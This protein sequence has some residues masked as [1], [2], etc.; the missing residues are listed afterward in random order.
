MFHFRRPDGTPCEPE[1]WTALLLELPGPIDA[2]TDW[3]ITVNGERR[4]ATLQRVG[5]HV[6]CVCP[7]PECGAGRYRIVADH[8]EIGRC[9]HEVVVPA[10]KL[11]DGALPRILDDLNRR[12]PHALATALQRGGALAGLNFSAPEDVTPEAEFL[13]LRDV[14]HGHDGSPGLLRL[15]SRIAAD[16]HSVLCETHLEVPQE[17]SRRPHAVLLRQALYRQ[18]QV[19]D[20]GVPPR[21]TDRRVE[22]SFDT[23]ENR[24]VRLLIA[25]VAHRL[26]RLS[27]LL[28]PH[29]AAEADDLVARLAHAGRQAS[30][31]QQVRLPSD[32]GLQ[33]TQV[34]LHRTDYRAVIDLWRRLFAAMQV[35]LDAAALDA[36]LRSV[37]ELYEL[38]ACLSALTTITEDFVAT[39][40]RVTRQRLVR[41]LPYAALVQL[42]QGQDAVLEMSGSDGTRVSV[43]F[44]RNFSASGADLASLSFDQRPDL[45]VETNRPDGTVELLILDPKYKV[46][47]QSGSLRPK[48]EDIDKMHT[49]RDAIIHRCHGRVVG[50][51]AT[52]YPGPSRDFSGGVAALRADPLDPEAL[53]ADLRRLLN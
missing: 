23:Y 17:R 19:D 24:L 48:K 21:L 44:Q 22:V 3:T 51:A 39:G 9:E 35:R 38:W 14:L 27:P 40:Y 49:Y 42:V 1:E 47:E 50:S 46:D 41:R 30:F 37:P 53:K 33:V 15:L 34:L 10:A 25:V 2:W 16:P 31:L 8:P 28:P 43:H 52:L 36:P 12:L 20:A 4:W 7:W 5:G 13:R 29:A 32:L 18:H 6:R 11:A 26:R 45:V